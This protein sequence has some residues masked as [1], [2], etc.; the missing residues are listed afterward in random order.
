MHQDDADSVGYIGK[1]C[2]CKFKVKICR[3]SLLI[4]IL[5]KVHSEQYVIMIIVL[6][7]V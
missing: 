3:Q 1:L 6:P 4:L 5:V 7:V 2:L